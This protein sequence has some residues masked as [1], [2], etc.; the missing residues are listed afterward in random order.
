MNP[1]VIEHRSFHI[2]NFNMFN[3]ILKIMISRIT[4]IGSYDT[5]LSKVQ[6]KSKEPSKVIHVPW[7]I[8]DHLQC[9]SLQ[10]YTWPSAVPQFTFN[11]I[12]YYMLTLCNISSH[13]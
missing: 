11:P 1:I 2:H 3:I 10:L 9:H 5:T 13:N 4:Q 6:F 7:L 12:P 8:P